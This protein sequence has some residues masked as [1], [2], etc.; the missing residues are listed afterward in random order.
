MSGHVSP[1]IFIYPLMTRSLHMI[2]TIIFVNTKYCNSEF[3][4]ATVIW[5][6]NF[7]KCALRSSFEL[8]LISP[9]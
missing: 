8:S 9:S 6:L 4:M 1:E 5:N 2:F 7:H 3:E